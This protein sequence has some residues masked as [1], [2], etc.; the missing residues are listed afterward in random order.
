MAVEDYDAEQQR[1]MGE[2]VILIDMNDKAT[3]FASK[4]ECMY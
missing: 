4:K 1:L 3:G 2:Q